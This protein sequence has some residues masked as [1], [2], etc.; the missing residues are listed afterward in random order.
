M[1]GYNG[2]N[3]ERDHILRAACYKRSGTVPPRMQHCL[4][5]RVTSSCVL[6]S[7]GQVQQYGPVFVRVLHAA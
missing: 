6:E 7:T 3:G 2:F 4:A 5:I 1:Y